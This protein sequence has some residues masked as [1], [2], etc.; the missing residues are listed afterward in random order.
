MKILKILLSLATLFLLLSSALFA[1][2]NPATAPQPVPDQPAQS[3]TEYVLGPGDTIS[4]RVLHLDEISEKPVRI[5]NSG[6]IK[7]PI[8]GQIKV[9][10]MTAEQLEAEIAERLKDTL[11]EPQVAVNITDYRS[12]PVSIIGWVNKPGV[13]QLEGRK[14]LFE[15]LS[16][17]DGVKPEAGY[18]VKITRKREFGKI[19]LPNAVTE[20]S[21]RY[22]VATVNINSVMEA[23]KP[24]EN[25]LICPFDVISVP[26]GELIYVIGDVK[27]PGGIVISEEKTIT[28]LQAV[29]MAD[30]LEK[31]ALL[32]K[33]RILRPVPGA[34]SR[35]EVPVDLKA[36]LAG[37]ASDVILKTDDILYI[38]GRTRPT[39]MQALMSATSM[40]TSV[41]I[42]AHY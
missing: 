22:S 19:P 15:V 25:I 28:V 27:K 18:S 21:G 39:L 30:G 13:V 20:D 24:E 2:D 8:I 36:M 34:N 5:G 41:A 33:A 23:T 38:P 35:E 42:I 17:A 11:N 4:L 6:N 31:T 29:S 37:G 32:D 26:K 1:Q 40:A 12:Q 10:G 16:L 9:S 7:L 3:D 14:T